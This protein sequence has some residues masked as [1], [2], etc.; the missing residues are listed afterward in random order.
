[1]VNLIYQVV[2]QLR[3]PKALQIYKKTYSWGALAWIPGCQKPPYETGVCP[4][5][6]G[7]VLL[8][9]AEAETIWAEDICCIDWR[10]FSFCAWSK[11]EAGLPLLGT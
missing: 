8:C 9:M 11:Y 3:W 4:M 2:D 7:K 5:F 6:S 1:M 10:A